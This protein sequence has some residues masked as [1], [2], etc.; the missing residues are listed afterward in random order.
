MQKELIFLCGAR[1]FH[2][3]DWY[4][5]A[6]ELIPECKISIV[7]D[8]IEGEGYKK[9]IN[10]NDKVYRLFIIDKLLFIKQSNFS[11]IWRNIIKILVLPYQIYLLKKFSKLH[12]FAIYH[13]HSMYY[14]VLARAA[15]I[16]YVGTPQGSDILIKPGRSFF[17][18]KFAIYG[19]SKAKHITVD[20]YK[21]RL[22]VLELTNNECSI[23]QNGIDIE[24]IQKVLSTRFE[25]TALNQNDYKGILSI[26]GF[27][28]LYQIK[29]IIENRNNNLIQNPL[30]IVYP[31][32]EKKYKDECLKLLRQDDFDYGRLDRT[33]MY[34]LFANQHLV[35]S[36]PVSD[37]SPRSVY[38]AIFCGSI[39]AISYNS[40]YDYLP[41]CMKKRIILVDIK[42]E[43]WLKLAYEKYIYIN[44][45]NYVPS[46]EALE[47]FDQRKSF[48]KLSKILFN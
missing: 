2:A 5:S 39:V 26:R 20:S 10:E 18:K 42:R 23:I 13:A 30:I 4:K 45:N 40:Y 32:Y 11:N 1:D 3:M 35:V 43:N 25:K 34:E 31:F 41:N 38:E 28:E 48:L 15:N 16:T 47:L 7:T 8:L 29:N 46:N 17:Y 33:T 6:K 27:T 22:G 21:M 37:S 44:Q 19:L 24:E 9:I 14:L 12:P 36:I